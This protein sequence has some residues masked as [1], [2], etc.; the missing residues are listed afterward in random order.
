L[1]TAAETATDNKTQNEELKN[2]VAELEA[3]VKESQQTMTMSYDKLVAAIQQE[4]ISRSNGVDDKIGELETWVKQSHSMTTT[5]LTSLARDVSTN[6]GVIQIMMTKTIP[7]LQNEVKNIKM[8]LETKMDEGFAGIKSM[9]ENMMNQHQGNSLH[10]AEVGCHKDVKQKRSRSGS[11]PRKLPEEDSSYDNNRLES[12]GKNRS[13]DS[14]ENDNLDELTH[15]DH[16][17]SGTGDQS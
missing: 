17:M 11:R 7:V 5:A 10:R 2:K 1:A 3:L 4:H 14:R 13:G 6:E 15:S 12:K 8:S 16:K 9:F